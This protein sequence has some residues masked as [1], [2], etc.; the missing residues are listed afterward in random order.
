[1]KFN[2]MEYKRADVAA[3]KAKYADLTAKAKAAT[4]AEELITLVLEHETLFKKFR[5]MATLAEVR[6]AMKLPID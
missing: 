5:T 1:M 4:A 6:Q 3:L 2:D